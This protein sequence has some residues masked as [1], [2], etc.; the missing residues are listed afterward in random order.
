M[1]DGVLVYRTPY[2][3]P[4][5]DADTRCADLRVTFG[6]R[7]EGLWQKPYCPSVRAAP[8]DETLG[9]TGRFPGWTYGQED[10][11]YDMRMYVGKKLTDAQMQEIAI[12]R[13]PKLWMLRFHPEKGETEEEWAEKDVTGE[14]RCTPLAALEMKDS[15]WIDIYGHRC[16][17]C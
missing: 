14:Y 8:K 12:L 10:D 16:P 7:C 4:V 6:S 3:S 5:K 9:A 11:Y 13:T 17:C 2:G 15:T 1:Q